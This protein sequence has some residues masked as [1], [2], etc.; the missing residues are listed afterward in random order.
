VVKK[1]LDGLEGVNEATVSFKEKRADVLYDPQKV[2]V[3]DMVKA[4]RRVGFRA[5]PIGGGDGGS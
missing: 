3:E 5:K 1:A 2:T 4:I